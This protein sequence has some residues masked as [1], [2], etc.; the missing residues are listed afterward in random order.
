MSSHRSKHIDL[1]HHVIRYH[2]DKG[3]ITL[4]YCHTSQMI[5]NILTKCL[6]KPTFERLLSAVMTDTH[7]EPNDLR[8]NSKYN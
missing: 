1:R 3:T 7:I 6:T 8:F 2:N 4:S 5:T